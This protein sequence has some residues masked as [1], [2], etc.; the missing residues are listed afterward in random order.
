LA[1]KFNRNVIVCPVR[2]TLILLNLT[3]PVTLLDES[4]VKFAAW[5]SKNLGS[6]ESFNGTNVKLVSPLFVIFISNRTKL[7]VFV[8]FSLNSPLLTVTFGTPFILKLV[9]DVATTVLALKSVPFTVALFVWLL[10]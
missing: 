7:L 8:T 5:N 4:T 6:N 3:F 9:F 2:I 10:V 1:V